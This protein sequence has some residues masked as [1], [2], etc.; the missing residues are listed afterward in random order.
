[1]FFFDNKENQK[2]SLIPEKK[3]SKTNE[4][5]LDNA[6]WLLEFSYISYND[7][8]SFVKSEIEK[9]GFTLHKFINVTDHEAFIIYDEENLIVCFAGTELDEKNDAIN[10]LNFVKRKTELGG[11][12][13]GFYTVYKKLKFQVYKEVISLQANKKR[14]IFWT[15]HSLGGCLAILFASFY[16][17]GDVYTFGQ[18]RIGDWETAGNI[19][20]L[21]IRI[22]AIRNNLDIFPYLPPLLMGYVDMGEIITYDVSLDEFDNSVW[23]IFR[24]LYNFVVERILRIFWVN[25][26]LLGKKS[27][28]LIRAISFHRIFYYRKSL[29]EKQ[30]TI[31]DSNLSLSLN[32]TSFVYTL[33]RNF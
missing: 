32:K 13:A 16:K 18:P 33:P 26:Y 5:S 7:N 21:P 14:N 10:N 4:F 15:G 27:Y 22:Y 31:Y 20:K 29:Y 11:I 1:M 23:G 12:Y 3:L 28:W 2:I 9:T 8:L 24:F 17:E 19:S 6:K 30:Y 25:G